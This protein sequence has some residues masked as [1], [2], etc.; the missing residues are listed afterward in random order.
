MNKKALSSF[1]IIFLIVG[2]IFIGWFVTNN[3]YIT[4][5]T[6]QLDS[7][8]FCNGNNIELKPNAFLDFGINIGMNAQSDCLV[9]CGIGAKN[10][11]KNMEEPFCSE[12]NKPSCECKTSVYSYYIYPL[13]KTR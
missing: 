1:W 4:Y 8:Y 2:L 13:F 5:K 10:Y 7:N 11:Y 3:I 9:Y 6:I 12:E